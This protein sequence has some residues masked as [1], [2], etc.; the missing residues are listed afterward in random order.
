MAENDAMINATKADCEYPLYNRYAGICVR[1]EDEDEKKM[2]F[3]SNGP[4]TGHIVRRGAAGRK[5]RGRG[6]SG[7]GD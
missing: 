6:D 2:D 5:E 4:G 1:K 7:S 3:G